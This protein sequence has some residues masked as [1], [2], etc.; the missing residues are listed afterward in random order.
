ML[1]KGFLTDNLGHTFLIDTRIEP[2]S[3]QKK[4]NLENHNLTG[5]LVFRLSFPLYSPIR[6]YLRPHQKMLLNIF[7]QSWQRQTM[8]CNNSCLSL[9]C[10]YAGLYSCYCS[11][12]VLV[13]WHS[14]LKSCVALTCWSSSN[15]NIY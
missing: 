14:V 13:C 15:L 8:L 7:Y 5:G 2:L 10:V 1:A 12:T 9:G 11:R 6:I 3:A 4:K